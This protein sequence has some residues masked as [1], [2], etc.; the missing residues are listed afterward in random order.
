MSPQSRHIPPIDNNTLFSRSAGRCN[1]CKEDVPHIAQRAH[2][3]AHSTDGPRGDIQFIGNINSY[4]N[5]ILLCPSCHAEVDKSPKNYPVDKLRNIKLQH[6]QYVSSQLDS[7]SQIRQNDIWCIKQLV[8]HGNLCHV[9]EFINSLPTSVDLR[10]LDWLDVF[11]VLSQRPAIYPFSD[12]RLQCYFNNFIQKFK[13]LWELVYGCTLNHS[14]FSQAEMD[15]IIR[16][17]YQNIEFQ[18]NEEIDNAIKLR[19]HYLL[20]A[21]FELINF[22]RKEYPEVPLQY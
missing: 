5:L 6:E 13:Q 12:E 19:K 7:C 16:R 9:S 2:I 3:I 20:E 8:D 4:D 10:V 15:F 22:L 14:H 11:N 18:R 1:I 21:H 17:Q